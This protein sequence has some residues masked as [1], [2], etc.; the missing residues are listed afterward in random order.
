MFSFFLQVS[1]K[2]VEP[3]C[4]WH[5]QCSI[6]VL[7]LHSPC[8]HRGLGVLFLLADRAPDAEVLFGVVTRRAEERRPPFAEDFLRPESGALPR[9]DMT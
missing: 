7:Y 4:S 1:I 5:F 3:Y 2:F 6:F 9:T 8:P